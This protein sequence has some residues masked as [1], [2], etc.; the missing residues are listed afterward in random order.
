MIS[1]L[2][3]GKPLYVLPSGYPYYRLIIE[4][5]ALNLKANTYYSPYEFKVLPT[6][7]C[8]VFLG[9]TIAFL[10]CYHQ[11]DIQCPRINF[12]FGEIVFESPDRF[13][14]RTLNVLIA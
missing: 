7:I 14:N 1:L 5:S 4:T 11:P 6:T 10:V 3:Q 13:L 12:A 8:A 9:S 2:Y